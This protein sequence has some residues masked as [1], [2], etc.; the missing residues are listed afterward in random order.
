M[1]IK[2]FTLKKIIDFLNEKPARVALV[3]WHGLGDLIMF[4]PS[5]LKLRELY[6][7]THIV[8]ATERGNG[9]EHLFGPDSTYPVTNGDSPLPGFDYTFVIEFAMAEPLNGEYTKAELC[10]INELGLPQPLE[11][12]YVSEHLNPCGSWVSDSANRFVAVTFQSTALPDQCNTPYPVAKQIWQEIIAAGFIPI[13]TLMQHRWFN[14]KNEKYDFITR[15]LRD[16]APD[17]QYLRT[18]QT[19]CYANIHVS[20]GNLHLALA[21]DP[22]YTLYLKSAFDIHCYTREPV[23]QVDVNNYEPGAVQ[24]WLTDLITG[25]ALIAKNIDTEKL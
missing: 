12:D 1:L 13:E 22:T 20:T 7:D 6:P 3:F 17:V 11:C 9:F 16:I 21:D 25:D 8:I 23:S 5:V 2:N 15:H 18:I 4:Y 24:K 19:A 14:P 10:A